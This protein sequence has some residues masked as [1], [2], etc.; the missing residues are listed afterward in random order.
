MPVLI[1]AGIGTAAGIMLALA[2]KFMS[3]PPDEKFEAVRGALPG[4]NCGACG[5]AGCDQYAQAIAHEGA[6]TNKCIPG[7]D[8]TSAAISGILGTSAMDVVEMVSFVACKGIP[9]DDKTKMKYEGISTCT[10]ANQLYGGDLACSYGCLG[11]GDCAAKCPFHAIVVENGVA[12]VRPE[13]CTGCG[14]CVSTCPKHLLSLYPLNMPIHVRCRNQDKGAKTRKV[15]ANGCIACQRC[16]KECP[17]QAIT[18]ENNI[19]YIHVDKCTNCR[20]CIDVCPV[21]VIE[22]FHPSCE[23]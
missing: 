10:A 12:V 14:L 11:Y 23:G 2:S 6:S 4:I 13:L 17:S 9:G 15:C 18:V 21:H 8:A 5:F 16:A 19:A 1:V 7:G 20:T 3:I 22:R